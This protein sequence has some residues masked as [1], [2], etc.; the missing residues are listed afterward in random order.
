MGYA[1]FKMGF[2]H[3]FGPHG[4]ESADQIIVRKRREI[5]V[6]GWT[7]WS[8]QNRTP[9]MFEKWR[10]C[11]T[12]SAEP[13]VLAFCSHSPEAVDPART[14]VP[15]T[16]TDSQCYRLVNQT[17]WQPCPLG[18]RVPHPF[19]DQRR[20]SAFVV[21]EIRVDQLALP[22]VEWFSKEGEWR[23]SQLPTRGEFLIRPGGTNPMRRR[24]RAVLVLRVPYLAVVS[25][26]GV[27][28]SS[29]A[30]VP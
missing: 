5:E 10:E 21:Q 11:L 16:P 27:E 4:R 22:G 23:Q 6:N 2:W 30:D 14:G 28:Q 18:I 12:A 17:E 13:T 29:A 15:I 9:Q 8:F 7:L 26:D 20:A 25:A 24:I 19:R 3:P 1:A